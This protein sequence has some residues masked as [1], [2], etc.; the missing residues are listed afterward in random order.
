M[1][2]DM[3]TKPSLP[4]HR[5]HVGA[6]SRKETWHLSSVLFCL[7]VNW[8]GVSSAKS[9][10]KFYTQRAGVVNL[11]PFSFLMCLICFLQCRTPPFPPHCQSPL[12][13]VI[14]LLRRARQKQGKW[15]SPVNFKFEFK[16]IKSFKCVVLFVRITDSVGPT[17]TSIAPRQRPKAAN[18][19]LPL[20]SSV[21]PVKMTVPSG[22][23]SNGQKGKKREV[24]YFVC[25]FK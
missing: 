19:V 4:S 24:G 15:T 13:L 25:C 10:C 1:D 17:E 3:W 6:R 16:C 2:F 11:S 7:P 12:L 22:T 8:K 23:V 14:L 20:A 9:I 21:T 5:I 18:N